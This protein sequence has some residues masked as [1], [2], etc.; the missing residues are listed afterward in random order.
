MREIQSGYELWQWQG[1][2]FQEHFKMITQ[3]KEKIDK[4]SLENGE[5][6]YVI[7]KKLYKAAIEHLILSQI[8]EIIQ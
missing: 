7:P 6:V 8:K 3:Y 5:E 2:M 1:S 4:V